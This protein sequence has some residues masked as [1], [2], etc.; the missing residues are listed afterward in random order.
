MSQTSIRKTL[1]R[2]A[3]ASLALDACIAAITSLGIIDQG[4]NQGLLVPINYLLTL[5]VGLSVA[6]FVLLLALRAMERKGLRRAG[7]N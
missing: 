3:Y 2:L 1:N 6:L 4:N 7:R 5:V